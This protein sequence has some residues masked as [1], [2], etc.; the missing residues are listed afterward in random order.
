MRTVTVVVL[1]WGS[2]VLGIC[3]MAIVVTG[4]WELRRLNGIAGEACIL[5]VYSGGVANLGGEARALLRINTYLGL[6]ERLAPNKRGMIRLLAGCGA[7]GQR[8]LLQ[9]A[10]NS[11]PAI[12][13]AAAEGIRDLCSDD[14]EVLDVLGSLLQDQDLGVR[15]Q[16]HYA[17]DYL[18]AANGKIEDAL[19]VN[20]LTFQGD[21]QATAFSALGRIPRPEGREHGEHADTLL[22]CALSSGDREKQLAASRCAMEIGVVGKSVYMALV[23]CLACPDVDVNLSAAA[24]IVRMGCP[25]RIDGDE[26]SIIIA[27]GRLGARFGDSWCTPAIQLG[28]DQE[29]IAV[30]ASGHTKPLVRMAA[31]CVIV[32]PGG[33][34]DEGATVLARMQKDQDANVRWLACRAVPAPR[35]IEGSEDEKRAKKG[36][37]EESKGLRDVAK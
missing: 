23:D 24:A 14:P 5:G 32:L 28:A 33:R 13:E 22:S 20:A 1:R 2:L 21:L 37:D 4:Y 10:G 8:L 12:R 16:A 34:S 18:R 6:P 25:E 31:A 30:A 17:C 27:R 36:D 35:P 19:I 7:E 11:S 15:L 29:R 26:F 9:Y 3:V